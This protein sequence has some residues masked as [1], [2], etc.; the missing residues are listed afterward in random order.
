M[1]GKAGAD[2]LIIAFSTA[3]ASSTS[4]IALILSLSFCSIESLLVIVIVESKR[5]KSYDH[6]VFIY[7]ICG[8]RVIIFSQLCVYKDDNILYSI[9][10]NLTIQ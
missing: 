9:N 8:C 10:Q 1:E 7:L 3:T 2:S 4:M 5:V 6:Y